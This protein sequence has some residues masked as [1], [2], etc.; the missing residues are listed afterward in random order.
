ML[1]IGGSIIKY[2]LLLYVPPLLG[3]GAFTPHEVAGISGL[4]VLFTTLAGAL[5]FRRTPYFHPS[6]I[7]TMGLGVLAGS[8]TGGFGSRFVSGSWVN[9]TYAVLATI[10]AILMFMPDRHH[11]EA[12]AGVYVSF[13]PALAGILAFITGTLSGIIGAGGAFILLPIMLVVLKIPL[14]IAIASSL[15]IAFISSLGTAAGK[16]IT[17]QVLYGPAAVMILASVIASPL[18]AKIS[19]R[20]NARVLRTVLAALVAATAIQVW[21]STLST[22]VNA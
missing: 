18:G 11:K 15:A 13:S 19:M 20:V 16:I 1:G 9:V 4:E 17:G 6:L 14:R 8:F 10:A 22:M 3:V 21:V 7:I 12:D 5:T 2:P